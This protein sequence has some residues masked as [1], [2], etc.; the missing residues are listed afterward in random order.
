MDEYKDRCY[1]CWERDD[2]LVKCYQCRYSVCPSCLVKDDR[3]STVVPKLCRHDECAYSYMSKEEADKQNCFVCSH[4]PIYLEFRCG[5]CIANSQVDLDDYKDTIISLVAKNKFL[6]KATQILN[7]TLIY[8]TIT[9]LDTGEIQLE[10]FWE[11]QPA[12]NLEAPS[13]Y[14]MNQT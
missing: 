14:L 13:D 1:I 9:N 2:D 3:F 11:I 5:M 4:Q 12:S 7:Q 6:I 8:Y 10:H